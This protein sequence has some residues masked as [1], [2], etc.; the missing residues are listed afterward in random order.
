MPKTATLLVVTVPNM[1]AHPHNFNADPDPAFHF[2]ADPDPACHFNANPDPA[3]QSDGICDQSLDYRP[4]SLQGSILSL[5]ASIVSVH[6]SIFS[7]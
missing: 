5:Q 1:V 4:S 2:S 7:L 3:H 6:G